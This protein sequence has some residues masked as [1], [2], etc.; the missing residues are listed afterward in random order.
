MNRFFVGGWL[1][2]LVVVGGCGSAPAEA[3]VDPS[4]NAGTSSNAGSGD[5]IGQRPLGDGGG[6]SST[7]PGDPSPSAGP[8]SVR[9]TVVSE[10]RKPRAGVKV[11]FQ[12][13]KGDVVL[14]TVSDEAGRAAAVL[15]A[16]G[17]TVTVAGGNAAVDSFGVSMLTIA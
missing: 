16:E 4:S 13:A 15:P 14:D 1:P 5:E 12:N 2:A 8:S 6:G 7:A 3:T 17:G 9:V 11:V 10:V